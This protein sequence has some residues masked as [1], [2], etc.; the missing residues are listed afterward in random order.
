M[1]TERE[2]KKFYGP[3]GLVKVADRSKLSD[4]LREGI[5]AFHNYRSESDDLADWR[6]FYLTVKGIMDENN[7][8]G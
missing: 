2:M 1:T 4:A 7:P 6:A 8:R 5:K 3:S